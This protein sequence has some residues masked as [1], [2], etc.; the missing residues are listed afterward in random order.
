MLLA[1]ALCFSFGGFYLLNG[2]LEKAPDVKEISILPKENA[3]FIYDAQ[4]DQIQQIN[5]PESNRVMVS[6][7]EIP[8][9]MQH[10]IVAIEDSRFY[11]HKGIDPQGILRAGIRAVT[12]GFQQT[13]GASTITQ[14]LLKNNVFTGWMEESTS[15]SVVRKIQEQYLALELERML[16]EEGQDAKEVI[17]EAYLNTVNF[18][19]G[20]YGVQMAAQTYFGK[21]SSEL[22]LSECAVLAAIPQNPTRWNPLRNPQENVQRMRT[23]LDYM[24]EQGWI[25]QEEH[26]EALNDDVYARITQNAGNQNTDVTYSYFVDALLQQVESDLIEQGGYTQT[27]A[28]NAV[29]SGGLRIYST[30]DS[31]VQEIMETEF[32]NEENYPEEVQYSLEWALTT[33]DEN[34]EK[35]N[36]SEEQLEAYFQNSDP[37]FDRIFDTQEEAQAY[38][39]QYKAEVV[40]GA[41]VIAEQT[42]FVPQPQAAMTVMDQSTGQVKGIVGGRGE[43]SG[44]LTLSRATDTQR[45]PGS[46]FKILSAYGPA[47]NDGQITLATH[48][49]DEPYEYEDGTELYNS[50]N[51]YHGSVSV[52]TAIANSYNI[53]AVKVLTDLTPQR[54]M[55]YL[56]QL[57]F[58]SLDDER[59]AVQ[60]LA[61]G[62]ITHGVS[63]LE[64]AAAYAAIA[65][66]GTYVEPAFYTTV[67]DQEGKVLLSRSEEGQR[68]FKESTAYLLT[69]AM[70]DVVE[71]GTGT[72]FRL[73]DMSLAGKTGTTTD[74]NDLVFAGFTPY[75]TGAIWIGYDTNQSLSSDER[76]F[77]RILWTRVMN[78]IHEDL[79]DRE[80]E[81]P[82]SVRQVSVCSESGLLAGNG[83]TRIEEYFDSS[84]V[85]TETCDEHVRS[86]RAPAIP[87]TPSNRWRDFWDSYRRFFGF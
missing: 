50:D 64:L 81:A 31:Q 87:S 10:A 35:V 46:A 52:R 18:G 34:G 5:T 68:V 16:I 29:Y 47:L 83:C 36:Y 72:G 69:S 37:G 28:A 60:P 55:E 76:N 19:E 67:T 24:E 77:H 33:E 26:Q 3:T 22:T 45:Q 66:G 17:L 70:E 41:D 85:P 82:S 49:L 15:D 59:D 71:S 14:Q 2:I 20:A 63:N 42:M 25:S 1:A 61:L 75:Y 40:G 12:S 58:Q 43:K 7:E 39:D 62:G 44:S 86:E 79:S 53:P 80:F 54:G 32:Q 78:Q 11:E 8:E 27:Q 84:N 4:G 30:Q 51:Q 48:I 23:V 9:D 13:E 38:I 73:N 74:Y 6:I 56:H 57:G 65:N 21:D